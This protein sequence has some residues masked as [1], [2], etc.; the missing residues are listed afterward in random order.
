[1]RTQSGFFA[2]K[3]SYLDS[4][5]TNDGTFQVFAIANAKSGSLN[6]NSPYVKSQLNTL[7]TNGHAYSTGVKG[8]FATVYAGGND[9]NALVAQDVA[10]ATGSQFSKAPGYVKPFKVC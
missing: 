7:C 10:Q 4:C 9:D 5:A 2:K 3:S 6:V 8:V 1:V